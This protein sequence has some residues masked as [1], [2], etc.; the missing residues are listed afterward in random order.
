MAVFALGTAPAIIFIGSLRGLLKSTFYQYFMKTVAVG[1]LILGV[2]YASNFLSIY[3][4]NLSNKPNESNK[5]NLSPLE[6]GKQ[7]INMDV[8]SGGYSPNQFTI[9]KG[10][11]VKW[12]ING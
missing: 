4:I 11:P 6:N 9:K 7:I 1:V 10:I 2:Y 5:S 8:I 12:V 3:G